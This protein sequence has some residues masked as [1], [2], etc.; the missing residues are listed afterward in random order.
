M[1]PKMGCFLVQSHLGVHIFTVHK[2]PNHLMTKN[3][4]IFPKI[5]QNLIPWFKWGPNFGP[6]PGP[7]ICTLDPK[8]GFFLY[9]QILEKAHGPF[10]EKKIFL[11]KIINFLVER[12]L[13][14][15]WVIYVYIVYL[16]LFSISK[17]P[18]FNLESNLILLTSMQVPSFC[19]LFSMD[20][21]ACFLALQKGQYYYSEEVKVETVHISS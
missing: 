18:S 17:W 15:P 13:S 16:I 20:W 6:S 8:N 14:I 21:W 1:G 2:Y 4:D 11:P 12:L 7:H 9:Y 3:P 19:I 5:S 10:L